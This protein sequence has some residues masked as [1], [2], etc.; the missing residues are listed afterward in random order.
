[1]DF[2]YFEA[3]LDFNVFAASRAAAEGSFLG[4]NTDYWAGAFNTAALVAF[5]SYYEETRT[6]FLEKIDELRKEGENGEA[7]RMQEWI[8]RREPLANNKERRH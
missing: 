5:D 4:H 1:M 3:L 6:Y 8:D 2:E 7:D